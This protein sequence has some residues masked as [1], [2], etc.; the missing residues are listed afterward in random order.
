MDT[1]TT[2]GK[3]V[4]VRDLAWLLLPFSLFA[5]VILFLPFRFVFELDRDEGV[6]LIKSVLITQGDDLYSDSR[7][8]SE[9]PCRAYSGRRGYRLN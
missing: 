4:K 9:Y 6:N 5:L 3:R 2:Q 1:F 8:I 7:F